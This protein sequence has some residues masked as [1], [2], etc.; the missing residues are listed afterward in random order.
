MIISASRRTDIPK[1]YPEWFMNRVRTGYCTFPNPFNRKQVIE[2]SLRPD[3][4]D[5]IVFWSKDPKPLV[6]HLDELD[7]M[8]FRYYFQFTVNGYPKPIEPGVP[9][10][11]EVLSTFEQ[12]SERVS[13]ERVI[14]RYDPIL[15][16]NATGLG[17]HEKRFCEIASALRGKTRRVVI[18]LVDEYRGAARRLGLLSRHGLYF[19]PCTPENPDIARLLSIIAQVA[20]ENGMEVVSCAEEYD[21]SPFGIRPGKCIDD[22]Y[23][24]KVF[25]IAVTHKKD[26]SQRAACGCVLSKDIGVYGTCRHGCAYCYATANGGLQYDTS[27]THIRAGGRPIGHFRVSEGKRVSCEVRPGVLRLRRFGEHDEVNGNP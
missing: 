19:E 18:S 15:W 7:G 11:N 13:P 22:E 9:L 10:L 26:P 2:V 8:G 24:E 1:F 21:L 12:L 5:V 27:Y 3:D 4:V 23:I 16:S 17:Y 14:W 6:P 25:G 20:R